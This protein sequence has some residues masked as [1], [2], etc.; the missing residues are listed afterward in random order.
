MATERRHFID[1]NAIKAYATCP[2]WY[3]YKY[4][5]EVPDPPL[6]SWTLWLRAVR[7]TCLVIAREQL[8]GK[9]PTLDQAFMLWSM[10]TRK[11]IL[12]TKPKQDLTGRHCVH[13]FHDWLSG[14]EGFQVEGLGVP[15]VC[16]VVIEDHRVI[17][18]EIT[19]EFTGR[20]PKLKRLHAVALS[21][22]KPGVLLQLMKPGDMDFAIYDIER[23]SCTPIQKDPKV[24]PA[25]IVEQAL[26]GMIR[27]IVWPHRDSRCRLCPY[28]DICTPNDAQRYLLK[29]KSKRARVRERVEKARRDR[30]RLLR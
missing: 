19:A 6:D 18:V 26:R 2:M 25:G 4:I 8:E 13:W 9:M 27:K 1:G 23:G 14:P 16:P 10:H 12:E 22:P 28:H 29:D 3:A 24:N 30:A 11:T 21:P 5:Y 17:D 20:F 7:R 15:I